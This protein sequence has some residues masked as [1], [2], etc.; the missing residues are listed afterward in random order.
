MVTSQFQAKDPL[1]QKHLGEIL[2][3]TLIVPIEPLGTG[4]KW[5]PGGYRGSHGLKHCQ[6]VLL[7]L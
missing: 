3:N 2:K 6:G 5:V 1:L 4:F 7:H